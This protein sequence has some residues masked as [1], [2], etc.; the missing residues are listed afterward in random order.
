MVAAVGDPAAY[1]GIGV[2]G[3]RRY[4]RL[5]GGHQYGESDGSIYEDTVHARGRSER[6]RGAG[7]RGWHPGDGDPQAAG[8]GMDVLEESGVLC[9]GAGRRD[10]HH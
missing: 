4:L 1:G 7:G 3:G 5:R 6:S 10:H 2:P 8:A 9:W